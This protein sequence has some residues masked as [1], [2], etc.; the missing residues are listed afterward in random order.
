VADGLG[1]AAP[2]Q[3]AINQQ[4]SAGQARRALNT[5][6]LVVDAG[7]FSHYVEAVT[8]E[9]GAVVIAYGNHANAALTGHRLMLYPVTSRSGSISWV[10]GNA[11][12]PADTVAESGSDLLVA[13]TDLPKKYLPKNCQ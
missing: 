13:H 8:V 4:L 7:R 10:C 12:P 5:P 1:L 6:G 9:N 11:E 3:A 2:Y